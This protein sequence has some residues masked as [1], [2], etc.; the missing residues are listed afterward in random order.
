M[1]ATR[2]AAQMLPLTALLSGCSKQESDLWGNIAIG[3]WVALFAALYYFGPKVKKAREAA[4]LAEATQRSS[5]AAQSTH[6][7]SF[8][9]YFLPNCVHRLDESSG[10]LGDVF[11]T[12]DWLYFFPYA[13]V[14]ESSWAD[15]AP[16]SLLGAALGGLPLAFSAYQVS[17]LQVVTAK[18]A[19]PV[20][21]QERMESWGFDLDA[22]LQVAGDLAL[23]INRHD[24]ALLQA[25]A[26][27]L[28][29]RAGDALHV[30]RFAQEQSE[31]L[32]VAFQNWLGSG[33]AVGSGTELFLV[34]RTPPKRLV[35][36]VLSGTKPDAA[37]LAELGQ[38]DEYFKHLSWLLATLS[39]DENR[40]LAQAFTSFPKEFKQ[41]SESIT[42]THQ[43]RLA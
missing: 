18:D 40:K 23:R 1:H 30:L 25:S 15:I 36:L 33:T 38:S 5:F 39:A 14:S 35:T 16:S 37:E 20:A 4:A 24:V 9:A 31:G 21:H 8:R 10:V 28:A 17:R 2:H 6:A 42:G 41:K 22:R 27:G 43:I 34:F 3:F 32:A 11:L 7:S 19:F 26:Q 29:F 12:Q 13:K